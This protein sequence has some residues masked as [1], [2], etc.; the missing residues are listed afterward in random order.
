MVERKNLRNSS[1][2]LENSA[3]NGW[4]ELARLWTFGPLVQARARKF[5][6]PAVI[7]WSRRI[8]SPGLD[9]PIRPG[10]PRF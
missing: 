8:I 2:M 1:R 6:G 7:G 5:S 3:P 10:M 9:S 4:A